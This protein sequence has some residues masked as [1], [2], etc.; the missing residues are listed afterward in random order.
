MKQKS[1]IW[2]VTRACPW[3]CKF[4][5]TAATY[6]PHFEKNNQQ[7]CEE[8]RYK[9]EL[10]FREKI[11]IIG[12]MQKGDFK[13]DFSGGE[14]FIDPLNT[15]LILC[16][17]EKLGSDN[18]GV[19]ASGA[20]V[21]DDLVKVLKNKINDFEITVD[22]IPFRHCGSRPVGYHEY[23]QNAI[24]KLKENGIKVGIQTVLTN[25]NID[26]KSLS[27]LFQWAESLEIDGWSLLR[28]FPV[29]RGKKFPQLMPSFE[30][31]CAAVDFIKEMSKHTKMEVHFQYLLPNHP[32]Y[33]LDCRAVKKS[34]GILP[35]GLVIGCFWCLDENMNP[36]NKEF[37]LGNLS[38]ENLY[39]ILKNANSKKWM[40]NTICPF[41]KYSDLEKVI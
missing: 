1:I 28:F 24:I 29:G 5:C 11:E 40:G 6:I 2:N 19:S 30:H 10:S 22:C 27:S 21:T 18:I 35:D 3:N 41:F 34:F 12:Q 9:N 4:C 36:Q 23:A 20:F 8:Y 16:A 32:G 7:K 17:S 15:D 33:T 14:L 25:E 38:E 31:Y 13:I 26:R 39:S 37:V